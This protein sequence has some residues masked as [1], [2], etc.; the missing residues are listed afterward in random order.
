[1]FFSLD[2]FRSYLAL[3]DAKACRVMWSAVVIDPF[4]NGNISNSGPLRNESVANS[5][6]YIPETDQARENSVEM[7]SRTGIVNDNAVTINVLPH[8]GEYMSAGAM[9][10]AISHLRA[11]RHENILRLLGVVL[12][13]PHK[14]VLSEQATRGTLHELLFTNAVAM[15]A[16]FKLSV[17]ADIAAGMKYIHCSPVGL[18]GKLSSKNCVIDAKWACKISHYWV[19]CL[20]PAGSLTMYL[21]EE[22]AE[23]LLWTA[24]EVMRGNTYIPKSD[25]FSYGIILQEIIMEDRPYG[26]NLPRLEA[27]EILKIIQTESTDVYRPFIPDSC[28]PDTWKN[29]AESCWK[30]Q[31]TDRPSFDSIVSLLTM[32]N[33]G[34]EISLADSMATRLEAHTRHLED[35]V[36]ERSLELADE[37]VRMET[38][39]CELLPKSVFEQMKAGQ[40]I[41]PESFEQVTFFNSDIVG[42]TS[43]SSQST[44]M[45][46]VKL[47]NSMYSVFDE[48]LSNYDVYK[49][50]TIG[51]AYV[52]TSGL[53]E[54][55][56]DQHAREIALM[57]LHMLK[58]LADFTIPHVP[59]ES[60][61]MRIGL[62]TGS[63]VAGVTG[64]KT[65]RYLL[66][67]ETV[68]TAARLEAL[69]EPM[70]IHVSD[71]TTTLLQKDDQFMLESR[72]EIHVPGHGIMC[73]SW[74]TGSPDVVMK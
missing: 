55:N 52:V 70:R 60:I 66:F 74:L 33:G 41:R 43:I 58:T 23:D 72:G 46:V 51:D 63:C 17:L 57:S 18:H 13:S 62:H 1:M 7:F 21:A 38:L 53:P 26:A 20:S 6:S 24:P 64:I 54:R 68:N 14:C 48:V 47:L 16:D 28:C 25:V 4:H 42:F 49:V 29:L 73:T 19:N 44:P 30:E 67:G 34:R 65:P 15:T 3:R 27:S 37:K 5:P 59:S 11:L 56:G 2:V 39:L 69:G 45:Q 31:P 32:L 9:W 12:E 8:L 50:A 40:K 10:R 61:V 35:V 22:H 71:T 36:M